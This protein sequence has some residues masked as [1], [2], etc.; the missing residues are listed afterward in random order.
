MKLKNNKF[1]LKTIHKISLILLTLSSITIM[2]IYFWYDKNS[3]W[4]NVNFNNKL[5]EI[6]SEFVSDNR[7]LELDNDLEEFKTL[8]KE[9]NYI[10]K[11]NKLSKNTDNILEKMDKLIKKYK[12]KNGNVVKM[13]EKL[14]LYK[15]IFEFKE[16]AY[17]D[18][19]S[20]KLN[21][22]YNDLTKQYLD[23]NNEYDKVLLNDLKTIIDN[24]NE[25]GTFIDNIYKLGDLEN[26]TL[27]IY[28]NVYDFNE[29]KFNNLSKF[30]YIT[31]LEVLFKNNTIIQNNNLLKNELDWKNFKKTI[32]NINFHD[33]IQVK[34]IKT[35]KQ[36]NDFNIEYIN[37]NDN[38]ENSSN[39]EIDPNSPVE[40]VTKNNK[41]IPDSSYIKRTSK[42]ITVHIKVKYKEKDETNTR[43]DKT[44]RKKTEDEQQ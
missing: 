37:T 31:S 41:I 43:T 24:Y 38:F 4:D 29:L 28:E 39:Y 16:T 36:A 27:K 13:T 15:N 44:E 3:E 40:K 12:L 6:P 9:I 17:D 22:L 30:K 32:N 10:Q 11:N 23:T 18:I 21:K 26:N 19:N 25:L 33:Y 34:D 1:K 42:D 14:K 5:S 7:S 2:L 35:L 8:E 20:K